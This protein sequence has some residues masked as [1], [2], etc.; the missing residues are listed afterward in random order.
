MSIVLQEHGR[1]LSGGIMNIEL[2][3]I[4]DY[5]KEFGMTPVLFA[6][7]VLFI[8][9]NKNK[10]IKLMA[11]QISNSIQTD[12]QKI[13]DQHDTDL[14]VKDIHIL[15]LFLLNRTHFWF[16]KILEVYEQ[17]KNEISEKR[18][19]F[20]KDI[21][22]LLKT[23]NDDTVTSYIRSEFINFYEQEIKEKTL[24]KFLTRFFEAISMNGG[25]NIFRTHLKDLLNELIRNIIDQTEKKFIY[26]KL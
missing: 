9:K 14:L 22:T 21:S 11:D 19:D 17:Y 10:I 23:S 1:W 18:E 15:E 3:D 16:D 2:H 6:M 26:S 25:S 24:E 4:L 5:V 8:I 12:R 13:L 7:I 20:K